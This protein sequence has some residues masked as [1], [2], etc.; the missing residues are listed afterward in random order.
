MDGGFEIVHC[1]QNST[2]FSR[3]VAFFG[4]YLQQSPTPFINLLPSSKVVQAPESVQKPC[5]CDRARHR[6]R[7]AVPGLTRSYELGGQILLS[8]CSALCHS[9][10]RSRL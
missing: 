4:A 3:L 9:L 7:A 1:S 8:S 10:P 2:F 6:V 5:V